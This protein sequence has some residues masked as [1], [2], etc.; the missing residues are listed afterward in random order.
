MS[1][2][3]IDLFLNFLKM[4]ENENSNFRNVSQIKS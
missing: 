1:A 4:N 3:I 2:C